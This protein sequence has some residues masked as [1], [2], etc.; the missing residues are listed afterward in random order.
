MKKSRIF[1]PILLF[2]TLAVG[3]LLGGYL[4][5]PVEKPLASKNNYKNKLYKIIDFIDNEYVDKVNT[6]SIIDLTVNDILAKLDPHSVYIPPTEQTGVA[7][8]MKGDFVGIGVNFYMLND[9]VA[10]IKPIENGPSEKAGI[11]AGDRILYANSC[12]LFGRKLPTDSLF[13]KLKG[14]EGTAVELTIFRKSENKKYKIKVKR[15]V[16][17]IKSVDVATMVNATMGYIKINRF[18][19]TTYKEF[20]SGLQTLQKK[21]AKSVIIDVRENG[22]GYMEMAAEIADEFLKDKQVIVFLKN[23][24]GR[25]DKTFATEK[26][27][28]ETGKVFVLID[29]NSASASEILA[30]AIQDN[31]RGI[32]VGRR[33]FGKGLVQREMDF[34]DG[35]AVRLTIA[36][37]Y[38]P[39]GRSIQ[40][41]YQKG[42]EDYFNEFGKRF[43]NGELYDKDSIKIADTLKFKTLKGKIVYGGGGIVPDLFVPLEGNNG[44]ESTVYI[45]QQSGIVGRFAFET[46]DK[47]RNIFKGM[48]FEQFLDKMNKTDLYFNAFQH[49]LSKNGAIVNLTKS[50]PL[51]KRY[52]AAEFAKQLFNE[53]KFYEI[54]LKEDKMIQAVLKLK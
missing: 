48:L 44:N 53:Q 3:V 46:L 10:V 26:G 11:K 38:T 19:E 15:D 35:S 39:S 18:A 51:V 52:L 31:D 9:T 17:P 40:K 13:S 8:S 20:K 7:E 43:E 33:S 29:E 34:E 32:I 45:M 22:G 2:F 21:G 16:V 41:P 4:N 24:K 12:K 50:K 27:S 42:N 1:F 30:G 23:R 54:I 28:F 6:D 37:Y 14:K 5:F 47:N 36:R 49:Y 25:A